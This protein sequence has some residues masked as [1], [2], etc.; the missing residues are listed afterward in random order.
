MT[1]SPPAGR[2]LLALLL[3]ALAVL[4]AW[5]RPGAAGAQQ[6]RVAPRVDVLH[7]EGAITPVVAA[8]LE[9]GL[10]DAID[11]GVD[12]VVVRLD[13]PGG[14]VEVTEG[15]V[16]R[17][18][19]SEVPIV[20][21]VGPRGAMAASA[22]TFITLAAHVAAMAPGTTIG[23]ASPIGAQGE[24]LPE[25]ARSKMMNTLV[26]QMRNLAER[27][28][29]QA[30]DWV[31]SAIRDAV[32]STQDEVLHLGVVDLLAT[33]LD[34]LLTQLDGRAVTVR[35][36]AVALR[37]L[38]A[39]VRQVEMGGIESFLHTIASPNVAYILLTLGMMGLVYEFASPGFGFAGVT[40]AICLLLG[41]Y[42]L[43]VL[44]ANYAGVALILL[45]F[46]LFFADAKLGT[47]G[48]I[49]LGGVVAM[50]V[51]GMILFDAPEFAVSPSILW[52]VALS[53]GAFFAFA[54]S[55]V[56]RSQRKKVTTGREGLIGAHGVARGT[57]APEGM[58]VVAGEVWRATAE[59]GDVAAGSAVEVVAM[60]GLRLRVRAASATAS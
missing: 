50:A 24:E 20:V 26:A 57:L 22:G 48:L 32:S 18:V 30:Q 29:V 25:T 54:A 37:T 11:D 16:K 56:L 53:C 1:T 6:E 2:T 42:A 46:A 27:R 19:S 52:S 36:Q 15:I 33:D 39:E 59:G 7:V 35:E 41:V 12:A 44:P 58:V 31:E 28:G 3:A 23:A 51:G 34:D 45:A 49:A 55:A 47:S 38:G 43:G 14:S 40:G 9:R 17:M 60:D 13:T 4:S 5:S 10:D 8:Y 21:W